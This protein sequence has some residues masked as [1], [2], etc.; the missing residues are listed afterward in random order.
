MTL[1]GYATEPVIYIGAVVVLKRSLEAH[2]NHCMHTLA[3]SVLLY[4]YYLLKDVHFLH[5]PLLQVTHGH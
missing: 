5:F 3:E 2:S 4:R 1:F